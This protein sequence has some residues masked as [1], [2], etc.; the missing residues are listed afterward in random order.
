[1]EAECLHLPPIEEFRHLSTPWN[2]VV[3]IPSESQ[4]PF[5][6][7]Q[8]PLAAQRPRR[9]TQGQGY[10]AGID[11]VRTHQHPT[12]PRPVFMINLLY[13]LAADL[14]ARRSQL[15]ARATQNYQTAFFGL[16]EAFGEIQ[17]VQISGV[18]RNSSVG[19]SAMAAVEG[20]TPMRRIGSPVV[21]IFCSICGA[22]MLIHPEIGRSLL[23]KRK[24]A[25]SSRLHGIATTSARW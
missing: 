25:S 13:F 3:Y 6:D 7:P 11:F 18:L 22:G 12:R 19:R 1:M 9:R 10:R 4:D 20:Q 23:V 16:A 8:A 2:G 17:S 15:V 24:T 14:T 5:L 21:S